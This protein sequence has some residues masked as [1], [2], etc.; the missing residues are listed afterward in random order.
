MISLIIHADLRLTG[1]L[2]FVLRLLRRCVGFFTFVI[3]VAG[4]VGFLL[5]VV[6]AF[7]GLVFLIVIKA[8]WIVAELVAITHVT[9][10]LTRQF[11]KGLL[12]VQCICKVIERA[13]AMVLDKT[14]PEFHDVVRPFGKIT[15]G[16][17]MA[18]QIA[19][20]NSKRCV[21]SLR[22]LVI[23][24]THGFVFDFRVDIACGAGH[25]LCADGFDPGGFHGIIQVTGHLALRH[26]F[27][28]Y[29]GVVEFVA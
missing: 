17:Q 11:C 21:R 7:F 29:F 24:F 9:D 26:V 14:T 19:R 8:V 3:I 25:V 12:V 15:T 27:C 22:N 6:A 16:C 13:I 23:A 28:G 20:S 5:I 1:V 18:D 2:L 10:Q 4:A